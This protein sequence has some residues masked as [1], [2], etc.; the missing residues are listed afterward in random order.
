MQVI[1]SVRQAFELREIVTDPMA[2]WGNKPDESDFAFDAV[3]AYAFL[4]KE[5]MLKDAKTV[6]EKR[7]P[8]QS[9][10]ASIRCLRLLAEEFPKCVG[11][12][13]RRKDLEESR[14]VFDAWFQAVRSDLP[15]DRADAIHA[16]AMAEFQL[17]ESRVF[18]AGQP[19]AP[20]KGGR[21]EQS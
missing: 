10:I 4:I 8:E 3:G 9:L 15:V 13:F 16:E 5:R 18:G 11:V 14:G 6:L 17:F 7:Y 19:L 12:A 20:P 21:R 2:Y 1:A